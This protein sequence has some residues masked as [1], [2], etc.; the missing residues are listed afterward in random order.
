VADRRLPYA[1]T[2]AEPYRYPPLSWIADYP[3]LSWLIRISGYLA[4]RPV[5]WLDTMVTLLVVAVLLA[6]A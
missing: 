4:A 6:V 1:R 2:L 5:L 3:P